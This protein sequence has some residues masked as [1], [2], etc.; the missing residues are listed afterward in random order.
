MV[1]YAVIRRHQSLVFDT[2][3]SELSKMGDFLCKLFF[4]AVSG[5]QFWDSGGQFGC[6]VSSTHVTKNTVISLKGEV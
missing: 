3:H 4:P 2:S 5:A 6:Q 1:G